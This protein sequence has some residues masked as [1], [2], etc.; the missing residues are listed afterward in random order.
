MTASIA[1]LQFALKW[2]EEQW[3]VLHVESCYVS[4][5]LVDWQGNFVCWIWY[6]Y[7]V[8]IFVVSELWETLWQ[9]NTYRIVI[10]ISYCYIHIV[11]LYAYRIV[12]YISYC[13]I[14]IILLYTYRNYIYIY[15]VMLY[16]FGV[17]LSKNIRPEKAQS[18]AIWPHKSNSS[19]CGL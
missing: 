2:R 10:Y 13:Y 19:S 16:M 8:W 18:F 6:T 11:L 12:I 17:V 9:G 14:H 4:E 5:W 15:I 3:L 1:W 7:C